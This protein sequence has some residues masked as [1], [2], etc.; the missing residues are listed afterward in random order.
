MTDHRLIVATTNPG[1]L[2]EYRS[3]LGDLGIRLEAL[4]AGAPEIREDGASYC[5]NAELK[6]LSIARWSGSPALADDSGLEVDALHGAPGV[7][8]A[9]YAG[10]EQDSHANLTKL[11]NELREVPSVHRAARFR[12]VI[13]VARPDGATLVAEGI[14]EGFVAHEA[15]GRAGFGYDPIFIDS[16]SG[17]T[18]AELTAAEKNRIS[19]R[20]RACAILRPQLI[21]FLGASD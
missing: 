2:A 4:P 20:A 7:W 16:R 13:V 17:R 3:L 18:F 19:H 14:C 21:P 8:S 12:C 15:R 6:A 10:P 9:R 1:K 11:L 5:E